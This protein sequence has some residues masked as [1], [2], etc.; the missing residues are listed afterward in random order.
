MQFTCPMQTTAATIA[1][2]AVA[3]VASADDCFELGPQGSWTALA[4]MDS[5][6]AGLAITALS[7]GGDTTYTDWVLAAGGSTSQGATTT[8]LA[9][10]EMYKPADKIWI[11]VAEM[12]VKRVGHSMVALQDGRAFVAGGRNA[13]GEGYDQ[14][15]G[16]T[17]TYEAAV[18]RWVPM[19]A[20]T[21]AR[22]LF[23]MTLLSD[24]R[25]LVAG[26]SNVNGVIADVDIWD[27]A[28]NTWTAKSALNFAIKGL[29]LVTLDDG[30]VLGV[31][32]DPG[33]YQV[34][35]A[36]AVV[37]NVQQDRWWTVQSMGTPRQN[38]RMVKIAAGAA[39][40]RVM[41]VGGYNSYASYLDTAEM[42]FPDQD[43]WM[44]R[45]TMVTKRHLFD[46]TP[47]TDNG[48]FCAGG[49]RGIGNNTILRSSERWTSGETAQQVGSDKAGDDAAIVILVIFFL[50]L[51]ASF[52][53]I[54]YRKGGIVPFFKN[55]KGKVL[56]NSGDGGE[57]T[58][59][60]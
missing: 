42:Y 60:E 9:S 19:A 37:Y 25:V 31:G 6:R 11:P 12:S 28:T 26:G 24:G 52:A 34:A 1:F 20:M 14:Y 51:F 30:R 43:Q 57:Y 39:L 36:Q 35:L 29:D 47:T 18:D 32:G 48:V 22:Q 16:T 40:G 41:V 38:P 53:Y 49:Q 23:G 15:I 4:D 27:P 46:C 5:V 13:D 3:A 10:A 17:E 7:A 45:A 21:V 2:A 59:V 8:Y 58:S 33:A 50:G 56:G 54:H 44:S 55:L